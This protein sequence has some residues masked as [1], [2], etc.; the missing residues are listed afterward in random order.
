MEYT[1]LKKICVEK[2]KEYPDLQKKFRK[3]IIIAK[4]FYDNKRDLYEELKDAYDNG[5]HISKRYIIP[6]LLGFTNE[7]IDL[8][9]EYI[10]V[11]PGAS[12]GIDID[13][14]FSS[15]AKENVKEYLVKKYGEDRV[16]SV[17]TYSRLGLSSAA[18]DL[19]RLYKVSYEDSNK[20]TK[21]LNSDLSWEENIELMKL[22]APDLYKFYQDNI[23]ILEMVP[24]FVNKIRQVGRHAGGIIILPKPVYECFPVERVNDD[25]VSAFPESGSSQILDELGYIKFDIL[26]ISI[27]DVIKNSID[28]ID[29]KIY[30]IEDDDGINKVVPESYLRKNGI[31]I[32]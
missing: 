18:K 23:E 15:L 22:E 6:F 13:S 21:R 24:R 14:D 32:S 2:I 26:A 9:E 28:L 19:L 1:D 12:G 16:I 25:L 7:V 4:R 10:Q 29:E 27:L 8:K 11:M 30:L 20:F 31:S 3:E 5:K 17:G